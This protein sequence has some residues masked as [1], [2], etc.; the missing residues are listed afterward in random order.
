MRTNIEIDDELMA[1]AKR[2][3][4]LTTKR[5]VVDKALREFVSRRDQQWLLDA[6]GAFPDFGIID[7]VDIYARDD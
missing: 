3:S 6:I 2:V 4:G 1:N 5:E 7:G